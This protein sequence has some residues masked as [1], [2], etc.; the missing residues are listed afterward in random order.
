M[1]VL[2]FGRSGVISGVDARP[3]PGARGDDGRRD[4]PLGLRR[5]D[6]QPDQLR[7]PVDD[8]GNIALQFPESSG[9]AVNV[10]I[11]LGPRAVRD[12]AA[13]QHGR[14]RSSSPR[15][16]RAVRRP[17]PRRHTQTGRRDAARRPAG[18]RDAAASCP[19]WAPWA[20]LGVGA[21]SSRPCC[22]LAAGFSVGLFVVATVDPVACAAYL[23]L[24]ARGRGPAQGD[25]PAGDRC[26]TV[27]F[28]LAMIPLRLAAR[29][30]S[31]SNGP[32]RFDVE[33]FTESLRGV[34]RRGRRRLPRDRRHADHHRRSRRSS[35]VPIGMLAAIYL[36]E[37]GGG[38]AG[39]G[40]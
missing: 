31:S 33:F 29:T 17:S 1:T 20:V 34:D 10:L 28:A 16:Q 13:G 36:H 3:R 19:R 38:A 14:P 32:A 23:R 39:A 11:A 4:H 40:R 5:R 8:R 2:P 6:L 9:L 25:G 24:V 21:S 18:R 22:S 15:Q 26:V 7:Q 12:H 35:S 37:Y 30:R 27:A